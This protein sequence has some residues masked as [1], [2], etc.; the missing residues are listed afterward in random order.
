MDTVDVEQDCLGRSQESGH[1]DSGNGP[2]SWTRGLSEHA[3]VMCASRIG[4]VGRS[5]ELTHLDVR[6][7]MIR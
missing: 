3:N 7:E 1:V 4:P 2:G 5:P 6:V